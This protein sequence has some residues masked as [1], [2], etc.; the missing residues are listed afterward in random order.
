M[1][2]GGD[3]KCKNNAML[4][5]GKTK[6]PIVFILKFDNAKENNDNTSRN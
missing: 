5:N 3:I 6:V 4:F 2:D 1:N